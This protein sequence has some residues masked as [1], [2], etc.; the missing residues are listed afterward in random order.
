MIRRLILCFGIAMC[1]K[2]SSQEKIYFPLQNQY[3]ESIYSGLLCN[4]NQ[5]FFTGAFTGTIEKNKSAVDAL[6][7]S[8]IFVLSV[9]S[10]NHMKWVI[11]GGGILDD[12][13]FISEYGKLINENSNDDIIVS[14][15]FNHSALFNKSAVLKSNGYTDIFLLCLSRQG[16]IK[17]MKNFGGSGNES[18]TDMAVNPVNNQ[19]AISG[20][21]STPYNINKQTK[22]MSGSSAFLAIFNDK[23]RLLRLFEQSKDSLFWSQSVCFDKKNNIYWALNYT[24]PVGNPNTVAEMDQNCYIKKISQEG[25]LIWDFSFGGLKYD[26]IK[27]IITDNENNLVITGTFRGKL[28]IRG[29]VISSYGDSDIF[30]ARFSQDGELIKMSNYGGSGYDEVN[31]MTVT[32]NNEYLITG[33]FEEFIFDSVHHS[34]DRDAFILI[35]ND[36]L[37][38][39]GFNTL[40]GPGMEKLYSV[41]VK[42][43]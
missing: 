37:S 6:G 25:E 39:L 4:S 17:W 34:F 32:N 13:H 29:K 3:T 20:I 22:R 31:S 8:D 9:D 1:F 30:I 16:D 24:N 36:N 40:K 18:I 19:I 12:K 14:G 21:L 26:E 27:K 7:D 11:T 35:T 28:N 23:G 15:V 42:W 33:V 2:V 41:S 5:L 10:N 43:I 38:P